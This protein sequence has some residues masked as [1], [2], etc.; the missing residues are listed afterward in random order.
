[1][2]N[3]RIDNLGEDR[4]FPVIHVT[5]P[6][7][8]WPL[9][10]SLPALWSPKIHPDLVR[11]HA[12]MAGLRKRGGRSSIKQIDHRAWI[13]GRQVDSLP[14]SAAIAISA[15]RVLYC[16]TTTVAFSLSIRH[17]HSTYIPYTEHRHAKHTFKYIA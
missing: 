10:T 16:T 5:P 8:E 6:P 9:A 3:A 13:V 14:P 12:S 2:L 15:S 4:D 1:M 11:K 17:I 7:S